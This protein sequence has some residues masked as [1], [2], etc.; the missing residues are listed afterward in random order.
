MNPNLIL[1]Q[2]QD[3]EVALNRYSF[4]ELCVRDALRLKKSFIAFKQR[5]ESRLWAEQEMAFSQAL[6]PEEDKPNSVPRSLSLPKALEDTNGHSHSKPT[7]QIL[8]AENDTRVA[9]FF[10]KHLHR[11]GYDMLWA[12]SA[13]MA[14]AM[15][16]KGEPDAAI[17]S[18]YSSKSFGRQILGFMRDPGRKHIPVILVG[19]AEH[20]DA[21]RDAIALGAEDYFARHITSAEVVG[22]VDRLFK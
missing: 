12:S 13:S 22:K 11:A 14:V 2:L 9:A 20:S 10:I 5:I 7:R 16:Q 17:C 18:V 6:L 4:L 1:T 15:L 19:G 21:L 3:L 8:L